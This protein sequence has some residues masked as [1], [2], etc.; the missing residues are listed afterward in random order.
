MHD[1]TSLSR[2]VYEVGVGLGPAGVIT[3]LHRRDN[4]VTD[5]SSTVPIA[6][7]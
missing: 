6:S 1:P 4:Q 3:A 5:I 2:I 7:L